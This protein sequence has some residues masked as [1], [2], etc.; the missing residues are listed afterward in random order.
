MVNK[1]LELLIHTLTCMLFSLFCCD[2]Q[3][4]WC[5]CSGKRWGI[6]DF[7]TAARPETTILYD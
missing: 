4:L 3:Y 5:T 2:E 6:K 1:G 7:M